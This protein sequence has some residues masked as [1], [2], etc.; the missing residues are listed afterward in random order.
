[1]HVYRWDLDKTYLETDFDSLRGLVRSA[2]EP[3]SA[4]KDVPG[5]AAI[6]RALSKDLRNRIFILSGSPSQMR[7]TLEEK[8][9]LD[10]VR[11]E[12]LVLKDQLGHLRKG[13]FRAVRGQFGYKLPSLLKARRGMGR[14]VHETCFGD[15]AE[16]DALVYSVYADVLA[17]RVDSTSLSRIM[18]AAGAYPEQ[19][20]KAQRRMRKLAP[21]DAVDRIFIRAEKGI[22]GSRFAALGG[23]VVSVHSWFQAALVLSQDGRIA[24][25]VVSEV[26][27]DV[28]VRR[29]HNTWQM[30]GLA[31]DLVRRGH[32][33]PEHVL[34]LRWTAPLQASLEGALMGL[35]SGFRAVPF[36]PDQGIDYVALVKGWHKRSMPKVR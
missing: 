24:P 36:R 15:D 16:V 11:Y 3:A 27:D 18:E 31:Q 30:S 4:K 8:L 17:G 32:V 35:R 29:A 19:I 26:A 1:M 33:S 9:A 14:V 22:T 28:M 23:R 21:G 13:E 20:L 12:G 34:A 7:K 2:T 5:A 6:M 25:E 10:G